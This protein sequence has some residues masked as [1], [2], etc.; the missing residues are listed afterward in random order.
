MPANKR[1]AQRWNTGTTTIQANVLLNLGKFY[2]LTLSQ[3]LLLD[4]GT[5]Q[6]KYLWEQVASLRDRTKP[7]VK[8][9]SFNSVSRFGRVEDMYCLNKRGKES[10]IL[11]LHV[12]PDR[13]K[14][15]IGRPIAHKDYHHRKATIDFHIF[16]DSWASKYVYEIP[17]FDTY[18]DKSGNNRTSGTL[19]AKT[20]IDT[21]GKN[22]FIP[23]AS[24]SLKK[25]NWERLFLVEVERG[26]DTLKAIKKLHTHAYSLV[27][28]HTHK[29]YQLD[30]NKSYTILF[31]L[32]NDSL[33]EALV[34]RVQQTETAF[35]NIQ[36]YF[37]C[38]SIND[39]LIGGFENGFYEN[40]TTIMGEKR[41]LF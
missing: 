9:R 32:E 20:R 10:L 18:F 2:Y 36:Q 34:R 22:F 16:L 5:T 17:F 11:D 24:F 6:Y 31:L 1:I 15:P 40:W 28:R 27:E 21:E 19:R 35:I 8:S 41:N 3:M 39:L 23:D 13:I 33:K 29:A 30:K 26:V 14:M 25:E 37:L 12:S 38:K 4:I 7:L